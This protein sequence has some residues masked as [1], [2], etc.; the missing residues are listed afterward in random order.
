MNLFDCFM[1]ESQFTVVEAQE[2]IKE[3][4]QMN[5][6]NESVR[7]RIYEGVELDQSL[8]LDKPINANSMKRSREAILNYHSISI[9]LKNI[10]NKADIVMLLQFGMIKRQFMV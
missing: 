2:V 10:Q 3:V 8:I 4:K 9:Y 5:V 7:A 1:D 6:N